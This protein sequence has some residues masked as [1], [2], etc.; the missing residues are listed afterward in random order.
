MIRINNMF[1]VHMYV[2]ALLRIVSNSATAIPGIALAAC[3]RIVL[4]AIVPNTA[5]AVVA[6]KDLLLLVL[7]KAVLLLV[8]VLDDI[9]VACVGPLP[10]NADA[11]VMHDVMSTTSWRSFI[12]LRY[13]I[14]MYCKYYSCMNMVGLLL[15]EVNDVFKSAH[16]AVP[17]CLLLNKL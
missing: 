14:N 13:N 2:P 15:L 5:E 7:A 4:I 8:L 17:S 10:A 1:N 3:G 16:E 12:L 6:K 11:E 9:F